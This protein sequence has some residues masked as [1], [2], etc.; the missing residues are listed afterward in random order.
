MEVNKMLQDPNT[1]IK[2]LSGVIEKDQALV[3]KILRLV[4]SA[5]FGLR[6][7]VGSIPHA[8]TLLGFS[9][10]RNAVISVSIIDAFKDNTSNSDGAAVSSTAAGHGTV[11]GFKI[12]DLWKHSIAVAVTSKY[13]SEMTRLHPLDEAFIG[14][15]LH[16]MGKV[17]LFQFFQDHFR[18]VWRMFQT[19]QR[20]FYQ[21][22]RDV[23][24][25][26]HAQIGA[27]LAQKWQLPIELI[28]TIRFHHDLK[29]PFDSQ[30]LL[31][32]VHGA[33]L[34]INSLYT[35][36]SRE[37]NPSGIPPSILQALETPFHTVLDW[38]PDVSSQIDSACTFFI[39]EDIK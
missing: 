30:N 6:S 11:S 10:I 27:H 22:E 36:P 12:T 24:G 7:E 34:I 28:H 38:F 25:I 26:D 29:A 35:R 16:D 31:M 18:E 39:S 8:I 15:L 32:I 3:S 21:I 14:G 20:P 4:N 23:L 1:S 2:Q 5:F 19:S 33:N 37:I 17:A 9:T 13:L